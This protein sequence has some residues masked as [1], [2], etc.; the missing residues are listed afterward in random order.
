MSTARIV[1]AALSACAA[2]WTAC[3]AQDPA[4]EGLRKALDDQLEGAWVYDDIAAGF[5]EARATGKPM[6]VVFR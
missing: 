3:P 5:A 2:A 1:L 4:R 6:L